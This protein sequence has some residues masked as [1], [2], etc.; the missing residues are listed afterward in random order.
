[1]CLLAWK[2]KKS[3][4]ASSMPVGDSL[5]NKAQR[6]EERG[7]ACLS[8]REE[9][10][11]RPGGFTRGEGVEQGRTN[12]ESVPSLEEAFPHSNSF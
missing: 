7:R 11:G 1:M 8:Q 5:G 4:P 2:M 12:F 3:G 10:T 6:A 9:E